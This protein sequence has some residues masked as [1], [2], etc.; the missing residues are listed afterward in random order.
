MPKAIQIKR[1][2]KTRQIKDKKANKSN[3]YIDSPLCHCDSQ[4]LDSLDLDCF[5]ESA[6]RL[7]MTKKFKAFRNSSIL[8]EIRG[9]C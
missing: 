6:I 2:K 9:L 4:S 8:R 3:Q 5:G 1:L 7:A